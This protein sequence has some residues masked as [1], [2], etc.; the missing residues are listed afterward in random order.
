MQ[1]V[2]RNKW[3]HLQLTG[4]LL[5]STNCLVQH[6]LSFCNLVLVN[7]PVSGSLFNFC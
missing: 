1:K 6:L 7:P 4:L 2:R 3:K 5:K